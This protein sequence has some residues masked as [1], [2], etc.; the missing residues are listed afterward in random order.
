MVNLQLVHY[1]EK[2]L[3][4]GFTNKQITQILI[5]NNYNQTEI[6]ECLNY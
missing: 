2:E 6:K 1:I 5:K 4:K 3:D